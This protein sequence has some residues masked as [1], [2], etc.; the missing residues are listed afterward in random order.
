MYLKRFVQLFVIFFVSLVIFAL[1]LEMN[2]G[3]F[4]LRFALGLLVAYIFLT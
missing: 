3:N 4:W 1:I 2:F